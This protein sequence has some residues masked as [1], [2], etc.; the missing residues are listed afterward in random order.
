MTEPIVV[1]LSQLRQGTWGEVVGITPESSDQGRL[2]EMGF[3]PGMPVAI[4]GVAPLGDPLDIEI[5]GYRISL[6]RTEA[7][8][9]LVKCPGS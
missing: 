4:R 9:I 6:R 8:Q 1:P 5:C 7:G 2:S 3:V